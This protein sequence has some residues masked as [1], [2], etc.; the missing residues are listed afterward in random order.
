MD[1]TTCPGYP[2]QVT[3]GSIAIQD[4]DFPWL[5]LVSDGI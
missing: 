2:R 1:A 3:A 5:F 4:L